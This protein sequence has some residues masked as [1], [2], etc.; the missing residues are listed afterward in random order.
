MLPTHVRIHE[1]ATFSAPPTAVF[2]LVASVEGMKLFQGHGPIPAIREVHF[3]DGGGPTTPG[4]AAEIVN[5][6]G[7]RHRERILAHERPRLHA[8]ALSDFQPPFGALISGAEEILRFVPAGRGT[9]LERTF[10][11]AL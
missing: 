7:S 1:T 10:T 11:F 2:D 6:D 5:S 9:R 3:D 8:I 4:S